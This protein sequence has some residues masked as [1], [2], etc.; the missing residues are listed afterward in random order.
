MWFQ[1]SFKLNR[2]VF[3]KVNHLTSAEQVKIIKTY[4]NNSDLNVATFRALRENY[5]AHNRPT[6][7]ESGKIL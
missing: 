5:G 7:E 3:K 2:L 6:T 1:K 4:C